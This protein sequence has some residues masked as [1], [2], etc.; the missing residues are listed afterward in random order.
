MF[1]ALKIAFSTWSAIPVGAAEFDEK[2][3]RRSILFLPLI[4]AVLG[5]AQWG[6]FTCCTALGSS[7][8]LYAALA[9]LLSLIITGGIH[10]DGF[11]DTADALSSRSEPKRALEIMKDPRAG[12]FAVIWCGA[13]LLAWF[14]LYY[15]L[16]GRAGAMAAVFF[17]FGLSR[18]LA[19][20]SAFAIKGARAGGMLD[21]FTKAPDKKYMLTALSAQALLFAAG[22]CVFAGIS[23]GLAAAAG[24]VWLL[25]YRQLAIKRFGGATGDTTGFF[26]TVCESAIMLFSLIGG[27][28]CRA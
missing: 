16:S 14:A 23:G 20:V 8:I 17:G 19:G 15:E 1:N 26:I 25:L 4:G 24:V 3:M 18:S 22:M 5:A 21:M 12:A 11:C 28:I 2:P 7:R 13:L 9:V 27:I 6:L 10:M